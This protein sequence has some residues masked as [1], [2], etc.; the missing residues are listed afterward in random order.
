MRV[1]VVEDELEILRAVGRRLR[2]DGH[3]A[4]EAD[5][6]GS[7]ESFVRSYRY[8]VIVLDR[9]LPD[10]DALELLRSW[11]ARGVAAPV[12]FLTARDLVADRVDGFEAGAD[13]YLV[14]PFAMDELMARLTAIARRGATTRPSRVEVGDLEI[15]FGRREVRRA[16]V[17]LTLRPKEYALLELLASRAGRVVSRREIV[18]GCWG[19]DH[20]PL[21]NVE[22]VVIAALRRKLGRPPLIRTVRG[23]GYMLEDQGAAGQR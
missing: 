7:A 13:D 10:G 14:K 9:M 3:G 4:D 8:D 19:E 16:G 23:A 5:D 6:G 20:E 21:S 15:D 11:R 17:L 2:A 12:L 18:A 22:E 1:L